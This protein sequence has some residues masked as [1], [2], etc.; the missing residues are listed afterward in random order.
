MTRGKEVL[1]DPSAAYF[2]T[3]LLLRLGMVTLSNGMPALQPRRCICHLHSVPNPLPCIPELDWSQ[4]PR[5][6]VQQQPSNPGTEMVWKTHSRATSNA[7]G[8]C[9]VLGAGCLHQGVTEPEGC[10]PRAGSTQ[11]PTALGWSHMSPV[12]EPLQE[13][14]CG[15]QSDSSHR[16]PWK[17]GTRQ[18]LQLHTAHVR[19]C[20]GMGS[21]EPSRRD[22]GEGRGCLQQTGD[23]NP[24]LPTERPSVV[25]GSDCKSTVMVT[26]VTCSPYSLFCWCHAG[27]LGQH[28]WDCTG[29]PQCGMGAQQGLGSWD[30]A[31]SGQTSSE[32]VPVLL[33]QTAQP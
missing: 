17:A 15:G 12:W 25:W 29:T 11:G 21:A 5:D 14:H 9:M 19:S 23:V 22:R 32:P 30:R 24:P 8:Y 28:S 3:R 4:A 18:E 26:P 31:G 6:G 20:S 10:A 27:V 7:L 1:Q 2:C 13:G 33:S 16:S